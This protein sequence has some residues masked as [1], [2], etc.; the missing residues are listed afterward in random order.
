VVP[1]RFR[2]LALRHLPHT[3][4]Y[5]RQ[6]DY[7]RYTRIHAS[8]MS[9]WPTTEPTPAR[10]AYRDACIKAAS[11]YSPP[12]TTQWRQACEA[13]AQAWRALLDEGKADAKPEC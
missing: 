8:L 7:R 12:P 13:A 2:H 3:G 10:L 9:S 1:T 6:A 4:P 11:L 5:P